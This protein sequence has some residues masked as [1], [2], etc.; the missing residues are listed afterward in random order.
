MD[1]TLSNGERVEL[2]ASNCCVRRA[3]IR[4]VKRFVALADW[5]M[6][7]FLFGRSVVKGA[8]SNV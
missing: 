8:D 3:L 5:Q 6:V 1:R 2:R 4:I 7:R